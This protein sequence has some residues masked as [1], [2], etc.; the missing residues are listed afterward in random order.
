MIPFIRPISP[1]LTPTEKISLVTQEDHR[2]FL[3]YDQTHKIDHPESFHFFQRQIKFIA[4]VPD[5]AGVI[6]SL[7]LYAEDDGSL[8]HSLM[9]EF[10]KPDSFSEVT[11]TFMG[12]ENNKF[13]YESIIWEIGDYIMFFAECPYPAGSPKH[14]LSRIFIKK[15]N[16]KF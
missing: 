2:R 8:M 1:T 3:I 14:L 11:G 10:G 9:N 15:L 7:V 5:S 16:R 6:S 4:I 13:R 12:V